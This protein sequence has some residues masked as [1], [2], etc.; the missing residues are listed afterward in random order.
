M[1][2][3]SNYQ[4]MQ[5]ALSLL[6]FVGLQFQYWLAMTFALIIAT[7]TTAGKMPLLLKIGVAALYVLSSFLFIWLYL[8]MGAD[9]LELTSVLEARGVE[10]MQNHSWVTGVVR[11]IIWALGAVVA[12]GY[13]FFGERKP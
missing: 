7:Y 6:E 4:A 10:L 3:I 9:Y 8:D 13:L 2:D 5:M 1:D 11:V 12:L